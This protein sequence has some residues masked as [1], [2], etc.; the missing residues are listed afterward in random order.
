[1]IKN[2]LD[3]FQ[4]EGKLIGFNNGKNL[5]KIKFSG[6]KIVWLCPQGHV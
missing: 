2:Y 4:G 6:V 1:M 5:W 3:I